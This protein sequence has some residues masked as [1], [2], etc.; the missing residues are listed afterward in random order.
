MIRRINTDSKLIQIDREYQQDKFW[1]KPE[2]LWYALN[3]EW[4]EWCNGNQPEWIKSNNIDIEVDLSKILVIETID[5]LKYFSDKFSN[6]IAFKIKHIDWKKVSD[7]YSGI[8]IQNY[9]EMKWNKR[10][11]FFTATWFYGWDVSSGCIWDLSIIKSQKC[12]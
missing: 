6:E 4:I 8:E 12:L 2:G 7:Q 10:F 5:Q 11:N 9:H 3:N 1:H